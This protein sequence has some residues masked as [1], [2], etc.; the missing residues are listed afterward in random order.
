[1]ATWT[2][3]ITM[4]WAVCLELVVL[5]LD[6]L[7]QLERELLA[8][9]DH[10]FLAARDVE[11]HLV[12]ALASR[13]VFDEARAAA[14][15]LDTASS[16]VLDELD[17]GAL[18][19]NDL[20]AKVEAWNWLERDRDLLIGPFAASELVTLD[21]LFWLASATEATLVDEHRQVLLHLV[22]DHLDGLLEGIL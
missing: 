22:F 8:L 10:L 5:L 21:L 7:Q 4:T 16:L 2:T 12:V 19:A 15:D 1:M 17:V 11:I 14:F 9:V 13:V 3:A 20:R 18:S 6:V